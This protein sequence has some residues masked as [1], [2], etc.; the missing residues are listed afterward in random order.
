MSATETEAALLEGLEERGLDTPGLK[1]ALVARLDE[2]IARAPKRSVSEASV[3]STE[4]AK[5]FRSAIDRMADEWMCP[6]TQELP[7]HPVMAEDGRFYER[8][9]I[10]Q[11][12]RTVLGDV[13]SPVTNLPM[14]MALNAGPQVRYTI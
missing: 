10:V 7:L 11:W 4:E 2:A 3:G 5:R 1:A 13:K 8:S 12:F 14:G 6:I 9:A